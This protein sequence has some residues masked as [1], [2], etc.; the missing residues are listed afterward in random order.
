[1]ALETVTLGGGRFWDLEAVFQQLRGVKTVQCGYAGGHLAFPSYEAVCGGDTGHAEVVRVQF[2]NDVLAFE[3]VLEVFFKVHDAYTPANVGGQI[4]SPLRSV[5][6]VHSSQ[7]RTSAREFVRQIDRI[8]NAK[9][10]TEI[11]PCP[12]FYPAEL[13]HQNFYRNHKEDTYCVEFILPKI[14]R[15][16]EIFKK[17][18]AA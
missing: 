18:L 14:M 12:E 4:A 15:S 3:E 7:Q 8:A 16:R 9:L 11:A 1:M 17:K 10:M 13:E 6:Y 2:D 5:I